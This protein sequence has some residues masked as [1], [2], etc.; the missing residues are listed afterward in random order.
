MYYSDLTISFNSMSDE[1]YNVLFDELSQPV[2][3]SS[4]TITRYAIYWN[5][6]RNEPNTI[7]VGTLHNVKIVL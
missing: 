7:Y 5:S 2:H 6:F 4:T 3:I 1:L